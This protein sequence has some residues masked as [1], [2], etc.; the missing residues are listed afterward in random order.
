MYPNYEH[1]RFSCRGRYTGIH[2][3][4]YLTWKSF[5]TFLSDIIAYLSNKLYPKPAM[6]S[7]NFQSS[8]E[9]AI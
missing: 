9:K 7:I 8:V 5:N 1:S 3:N 6:F 4:L 2:D